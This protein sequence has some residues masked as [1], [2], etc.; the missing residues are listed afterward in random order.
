MVVVQPPPQC[1]ICSAGFK[2]L[3]EEEKRN[4]PGAESA[5]S[6]QTGFKRADWAASGKCTVKRRACGACFTSP[7]KQLAPHTTIYPKKGFFLVH[8]KACG[9][10][11]SVLGPLTH[12]HV[13][14]N[15]VNARSKAL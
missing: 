6:L 3:R 7:T 1:W 9:R 5:G 11:W 15:V 4:R 14:E 2:T 10:T 8:F 13:K 12:A